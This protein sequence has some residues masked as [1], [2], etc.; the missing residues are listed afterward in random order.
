MN[1]EYRLR[2]VGDTR[3]SRSVHARAWTLGMLAEHGAARWPDALAL[4]DAAE[5][6]TFSELHRRCL[7]FALELRAAGVRAGDRVAVLGTKDVASVVAILATAR[8]GASYVPLDPHLPA[9]RLA[10]LL[11]D[12]ECRV[13]CGLARLSDLSTNVAFIETD[14]GMPRGVVPLRLAA[15][16]AAA[17]TDVAYVMYTSGSTGYPKGV[18]IEHRSIQAFFHAHN[19]SAAIGPGDRCMNTGPFHFDVSILDVFMPLYFGAC[20]VLTPELPLPRLLLQTLERRRITHFYAVGT[21]L[22]LMT[23]DGSWLDG[24]DLRSLRLLQTGAEVCNP[25]TVNQWLRRL[26]NLRFINSYGP[27]ELTVGCCHYLKPELGPLPDGAVPIGTLHAGSRALLLDESDGVVDADEA[28]GELL[29]SGAQNMRGYW[30]RPEEERSAL[31]RSGGELYY[32]TGDLV[33]RGRDGIF[34]YL[35]RRDHELKIDGYRVHLSEVQRCLDAHPALIAACVGTLLD[36]GGRPRVAAALVP[37]A[38]F[39]CEQLSALKADLARELPAP[40]VPT[41]FLLCAR[42]PRL[43]SG[44]TDARACMDALH[45]HCAQSDALAFTCSGDEFSVQPSA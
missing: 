35:G 31:L 25:R 43:A 41:R 40:F 1:V 23:G 34:Y 12:A 10:Y 29:V 9:R 44:K 42:L 39:G 22:G 20:A 5:G 19:A 21:I 24:Y 17:A 6:V 26:P 8:L 11:Q 30:R 45:R 3:P 16:Q 13:A 27:T 7:H 38:A 4:V 28:E 15:T 18:L 36:A 32:R 2:S 33:R 37:R 14:R